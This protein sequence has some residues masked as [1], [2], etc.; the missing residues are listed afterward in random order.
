MNLLIYGSGGVGRDIADL[1]YKINEMD[2]RW[3]NIC[4][5]DDVRQE[6]MHYGLRV[7]K[8]EQALSYKKNSECVIGIGEPEDRER[9]FCK[10]KKS[11]F[12]MA[13]LIHPTVNIAKSVKIGEGVIILSFASLTAGAVI[14]DNVFIQALSVIGHDIQIGSHSVIGVDVTPGGYTKIGEKVF[15]GMGAK[16]LEKLNIGDRAIVGMGACV[17]RDVPADMVVMGNPARIIQKNDKHKVF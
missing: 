16:I 5:I 10:C 14:G 3:D 8:F 6:E 9:L 17:Y 12:H 4:F 1:A 15:I 7:L 11:G 13:T 2:K